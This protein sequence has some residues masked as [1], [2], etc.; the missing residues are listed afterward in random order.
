M[1]Y[2]IVI[3]ILFL[4]YVPASLHSGSVLLNELAGFGSVNVL[5]GVQGLAPDDILPHVGRHHFLGQRDS[6]VFLE[7]E[8]GRESSAP[9]DQ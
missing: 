7:A 3:F 4:G 1:Q 6:G 2:S 8:I 9:H 5:Q